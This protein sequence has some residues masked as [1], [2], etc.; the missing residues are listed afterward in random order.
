MHHPKCRRPSEQARKEASHPW[1][2]T[3]LMARPILSILDEK[4]VFGSGRCLAHQKKGRRFVFGSGTKHPLRKAYF[5]P[6]GRFSADLPRTNEVSVQQLRPPDRA[7]SFRVDVLRQ[8]VD[9]RA[10]WLYRAGVSHPLTGK[11]SGALAVMVALLAIPYLSP[12]LRPLR[13]VP[14]PSDQ[15]A[16]AAESVSPVATS[17]PALTQG[18]A[19]LKASKNEATVTNALPETERPKSETSATKGKP[20]VAV[21]DATGH[22]LD[23][24]YASLAKTKA[25]TPGAVT[26]I[27][28]YGD[29]VITSDYVSG[30]MRRKMQTAFGDAGHGF[31][32]IANPWEWYFHN[33]VAHGA[34]EGWTSSR[35]TGPTTKDGMYGVGGVTFTGTPGASA[36]FGTADKGSFGKK[37]S[38]F[39]VY[40]TET[41][42]G[43]DVEAKIA[44]TVEKFSTKGDGKASRIKSFTVPDG[45]AKL[46]LGVALERDQPGVVYDALGANGARVDL[47]S[48]MNGPHWGEQMALRKPALI[49]LQYGTNES[50]APGLASNYEKTLSGVIATLKSSAP[51]ASILI[52]SP[53]DRAETTE[54]GAVRTK[55]IIKKLVDAQRRVAKESGVAFW[56][57]FEAMGGEGAMAKWMRSGLAGGDF[58]HPSPQGAEHI[59]DLFTKA[60]TSGLDA[61]IAAHPSP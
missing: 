27:L 41:P 23:A 53:L 46:S 18:E 37:V 12:R 42:A 17:A 61:W 56:N 25:K 47:L 57:T 45:E 52:A 21:E 35:I 1:A 39:D 49:V 5:D 8:L 32:L 11:T 4:S 10:T 30:T 22:A 20:G 13:I 54:G 15:Q 50:E 48:G 43:G 51:N 60:L 2:Q 28:H 24:F 58:T 3:V 9:A 29:S 59:G 19:T 34:G 40:Y 14:L 16:I 26:R 33:D 7:V 31:V 44:G 38:R 55:P 6:T 36:F